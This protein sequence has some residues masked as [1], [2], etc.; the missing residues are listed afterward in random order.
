MW[1][2]NV[3]RMWGE[4]TIFRT[5]I[6]STVRPEMCLSQISKIKKEILKIIDRDCKIRLVSSA[7]P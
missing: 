5:N 4:D 2:L 6:A 1:F 3:V 7:H